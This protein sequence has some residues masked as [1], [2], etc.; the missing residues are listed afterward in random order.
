[1]WSDL[2]DIVEITASVLV[3]V[4]A[5]WALYAR[6]WRTVGVINRIVESNLIERLEAFLAKSELAQEESNKQ[7]NLE[8]VG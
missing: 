5:V 4:A 7:L 2:E 3:V 6:V 8:R 1:M